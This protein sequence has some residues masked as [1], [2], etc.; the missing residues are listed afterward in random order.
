VSGLPPTREL[1]ELLNR[2]DDYDRAPITSQ[3]E[4]M[5]AQEEGTIFAER[6]ELVERR[7][8]EEEITAEVERQF[9]LRVAKR[10]LPQT[11]EAY[12]PVLVQ[13]YFATIER[14]SKL[15]A[16]QVDATELRRMVDRLYVSDDDVL[17]ERLADLAGRDLDVLR[18]VYG[19]DVELDKAV[20]QLH[21]EGV[22][23]EALG[24]L[25]DCSDDTVQ[26]RRARVS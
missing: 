4:Y 5:Q 17:A 25:L 16:A 6:Q 3:A 26:R 12:A 22:S 11:R 18:V 2:L 14:L 13:A 23:D 21:E 20:W 24:R 7:F 19:A 15:A 9:R 1:A 8:T 10:K